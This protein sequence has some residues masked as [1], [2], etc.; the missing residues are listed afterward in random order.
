MNKNK[1][2]IATLI[3]LFSVLIAT[4]V[5]M[6]K[7][8]DGGDLVV[9]TQK[10]LYFQNEVEDDLDENVKNQLDDID[11]S[12]LDNILNSL[13][14]E[15]TN[16]FGGNSFIEIVTKFINAQD[17]GYYDNFLSYAFSILFDDI[18][19]L[20]PYF[21]IIIAMCITYSL[22]S[23][24]SNEKNKSLGNL[25]HIICFSSVAVIVLKI[26]LQLMNDVSTTIASVES[27]MEIIFPIILTL[28]TA[29][30]SSVTAS[31]FQPLLVILTSGITKL[32]VTILVPIFIFSVVFG[33]IGNL[34]N[35]VRLD[36]FSKFFS[37][38]FNW[39]VGIVFTIF[40]AFL[41]LH[42]LTVS[43]ID[44]I[45]FKT[46]KYAIKSY[47]PVLGSYLSDGISVIIASSVLIK[48]AVGVAGLILLFATIF[49][50]I[51]KIV[52]VIL[53]LKLCAA[54]LE[55]LCEKQIHEFLYS[56]AKSLNML[57]VCLIAVGLMYLI[58][59]SLLMCCS[60]LL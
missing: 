24:L 18:I 51:I 58:S 44:S 47:V 3:F 40:I 35:N 54:I 2:I 45:S 5:L 25:I 4:V 8:N 30:G 48:N 17:S 20:I 22:I 29:V 52:I 13:G 21:A 10:E 9:K 31:T 19:E 53:L 38:L 16:I 60:N 49:A 34:S 39:I 23:Q 15:R 11:F 37:S 56:I 12:A 59:V 50:P 28:M 43:S 46:A 33:V 1:I 6:F 14:N 27:Q 26:V 41:T 42:G 7:S 36:K 32:F 57:T 55:P